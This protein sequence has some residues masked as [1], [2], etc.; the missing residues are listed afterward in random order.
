M[1]GFCVEREDMYG[2]II[3]KK[4]KNEQKVYWLEEDYMEMKMIVVRNQSRMIST[5]P[6]KLAHCAT[7]PWNLNTWGALF[8]QMNIEVPNVC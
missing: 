6:L 4:I 3:F 7:P 8:L 5:W 1:F 2:K